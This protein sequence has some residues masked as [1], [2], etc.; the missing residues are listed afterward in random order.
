MNTMAFWKRRQRDSETTGQRTFYYPEELRALR[1]CQAA[2]AVLLN[3]LQAMT[4][5][6]T[7][8]SKELIA[9]GVNYRLDHANDLDCQARLVLDASGVYLQQCPLPKERCPLQR[10]PPLPEPHAT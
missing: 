7:P 3:N 10:M 9:R 8:E 4:H 1:N 5:V 6:Q 2:A